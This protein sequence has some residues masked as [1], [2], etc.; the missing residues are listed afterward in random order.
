MHAIGIASRI[1]LGLALALSLLCSAA[2][3]VLQPLDQSSEYAVVTGLPSGAAAQVLAGNSALTHATVSALEID[4]NLAGNTD[5]QAPGAPSFGNLLDGAHQFWTGSFSASGQREVLFYYK[6]D[7]HWFLGTLDS[8]HTLEWRYLGDSSGFGNLLDGQHPIWIG[9]FSGSGRSEV[10]FYFEGDGNWWL[11]QIGPTGPMQ[12]KLVG[13]TKGQPAGNPVNFGNLLDGAHPF[14]SGT[15]SGSGRTELVFHYRGDSHWFLGSLDANGKLQWR[16][17]GD[18][19]GFG[20]LLDG[21][22]PFW[23]GSFTTPGKTD[24]LFYYEGDGNWWRGQIG[25]TGPLAWMQVGNTKGQPAGNPVNFG[26][27]LDGAHFFWTGDFAAPGKTGIVFH[28]RGDKHWFIGALDPNGKLQW[29]YLGDTAGFGDVTDNAHRIWVGNFGGSGSAEFVF[30]YSGDGNWWRGSI[31]NQKLVWNLAGNTRGFGNLLDASHAFWPA[32]YRSLSQTDLLFYFSGDGNWWLGQFDRTR[33]A[34]PRPIDSGVP[35]QVSASTAAGTLSSNNVTVGHN[36]PTQHYDRH[37]AGWNPHEPLLTRNAVRGFRMIRTLPTDDQVYAQP[38]YV[39][40][41]GFPGHTGARNALYVVSESGLIYAYDADSGE[42]LALRNLIPAGEYPVPTMDIYSLPWLNIYPK[43]GV[44]GTPVI[45]RASDALYVV[46]K[47]KDAAGQYHQ[48]VHALGLAHLQDH[49]YS[50]VE[51]TASYQGTA[52]DPL[53]NNQRAALLL[54]RG[55]LYVAFASHEDRSDPR[56][57]VSWSGWV[58]AY[59]AATLDQL[60]VFDTQRKGG[61]GIWQ[62]GHGPAADYDGNVLFATGNGPVNSAPDA[63]LTN[64][65]L[66]LSPQLG[67]LSSFTPYTRDYLNTKDW[68]LGSGGVLVLPDQSSTPHHLAVAAGKQGFVYLLDRDAL[69]GYTANGPD[70]VTQE[71]Q[72]YPG[73]VSI[74]PGNPIGVDAQTIG[75]F[76]GPAYFGGAAAQRVFICGGH[77]SAQQNLGQLVS[78][79]LTNS[80]L[81]NRSQ[82]QRQVGPCTPSVTS[83]AAQDA[84]A[85]VWALERT[86]P[87][88]LV[89]LSADNLNEV[90]FVG[91]A[92]PW[93]NSKGSAFLEPTIVNGRAYVPT[94]TGVTVFGQ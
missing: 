39:E 23:T 54:S 68:D 9:S 29:T 16:Y 20:D 47:S 26:N 35:V 88:R 24:L 50:P 92:G 94:S 36:Y 34:L 73:Q 64:S 90:L 14:W 44:T 25:A 85:V 10:L 63:N 42:L 58:L 57:G 93:N 41:I 21:K 74:G 43:I 69:G 1:A 61:S 77:G 89:A 80:Q 59:D 62:S 32:E 46:V 66:K 60:S 91:E 5:G 81:T 31:Q 19:K 3:P 53:P 6:G 48:R 45:D 78:Y 4:W 86:N 87:L 8:S 72:L 7:G 70:H 67:L 13:N 27:V 84:S 56:N 37:R 11:G 71:L 22:H 65:V 49:L 76:G 55:V 12:W 51:I 52:F 2:P 75:M 79:Q 15:F 17:L 18:T 30:Y 33:I 82:S 40:K 38:L 28:Y 83:N